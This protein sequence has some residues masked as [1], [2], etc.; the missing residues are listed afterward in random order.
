V[1]HGCPNLDVSE[2]DVA[3]LRSAMLTTRG[4]PWVRDG[5]QSW[6][7]AHSSQ[8]PPEKDVIACNK[9]VDEALR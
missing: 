8:N 7:P 9:E 4:D 2:P 1:S 3:E 6:H 5:L